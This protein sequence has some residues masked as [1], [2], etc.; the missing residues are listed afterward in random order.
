[1]FKFVTY[2]GGVTYAIWPWVYTY[3]TAYVYFNVSL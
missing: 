1:M 3:T 2:R